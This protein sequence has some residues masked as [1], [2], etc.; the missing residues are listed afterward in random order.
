MRKLVFVIMLGSMLSWMGC[1]TARQPVSPEESVVH[2][3]EVPSN[4]SL[5]TAPEETD[6][7][8]ASDAV[9]KSSEVQSDEHGDALSVGAS[10]ADSQESS[11]EDE[12]S[13]DIPDGYVLCEV[14]IR[15]GSVYKAQSIGPTLEEA[16]DNAVDE[17]CAVPCAEQIADKGFSEDESEE[18]IDKCTM[19]CVVDSTVLSKVCW[20]NSDSVYVGDGNEDGFSPYDEGDE[21]IERQGQ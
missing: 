10:E 16:F 2:G 6:K 3:T 1:G 12:L 13:A 21:T 19:A 11:G 9:D 20:V 5:M 7:A 15:L 8:S 18:A 14:E 17:A 4:E